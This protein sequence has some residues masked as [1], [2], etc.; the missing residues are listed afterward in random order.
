MVLSYVAK[1]LIPRG[2]YAISLTQN[3]EVD[4]RNRKEEVTASGRST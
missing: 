3:E 2:F 4:D 1:T